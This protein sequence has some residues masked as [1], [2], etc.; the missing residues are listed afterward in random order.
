MCRCGF[1]S[2]V[3]ML[4]VRA[5][6]GPA[7]LSKRLTHSRRTQPGAPADVAAPT[8]RRSSRVTL[9][10]CGAA[11]GGFC[12]AYAMLLA[13]LAS[14]QAPGRD[15]QPEL[16][17]FLSHSMRFTRS[18]LA[19][20]QG[21]RVVVRA[22]EPT[23]AGEVGVVGAV[24]VHARRQR[25]VERYRDIVE[26]KKGPDVL[27]IGL[28]S[29]PPAIADLAPLDLGKEDVDLRGCRVGRCDVRLSADEIGRFQH[30]IDWNARDADQKAAL[31]FKEVLLDHVR[32]Y[33]SGRTKGRIRSYEDGK[34]TIHPA[35]EFAGLSD[36]L[37]GFPADPVDGAEDFLYWSKEKFGFA[38]FVSVTH[39]TILPSGATSTVVASKDVYSSR[40]FDASLS[41]T[42]ASDAPGTSEEIYLVYVNRSRASALRGAFAGLRRSI[43]ERRAKS[44]LD[45]QLKAVKLRLENAA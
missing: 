10:G 39:L 26:F 45:E 42:L 9:P 3:A 7:A 17:Q 2:L 25:F 16:R 4:F 36:H 27:Q 14:A 11:A 40:Y 24:R 1:T 38:P 18:D 19:D 30:E 23:S 21:G 37:R 32:A 20:L 29:H 43:V 22:L 6:R 33:L 12:G 34:R 13:M 44:S 35:D 5:P 28:F 15:L 8:P 41:V 31:L